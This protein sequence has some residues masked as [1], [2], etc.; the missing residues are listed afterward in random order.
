MRRD[1]FAVG[2]R[3]ALEPYVRFRYDEN[4]SRERRD[5][6]LSLSTAFQLEGDAQLTTTAVFEDRDYSLSDTSDGPYGRLSIRYSYAF[7]EKTRLAFGAALARSSPESG[8]L[9]Y[10][11]AQVS[12]D[13]TR[14]F[15]DVG[16][17]GL[18]GRYSQRNHDELFPATTL[19]RADD[20]FTLGLSFMPARFELFGSRP[21][22]SCQIERTSS[23]IALYDYKSTDC[24]L[25][26]E[27][28]F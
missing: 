26:F 16:T 14:R 9:R 27:R 24:G 25:T 4:Q 19:I 10:W 1:S 20:K 22:A 13:A 2:R 5:V 11:E 6:G 12:A 8:H 18:F 21:K 17:F 7:D 28:T 3:T 15:Q 23:N